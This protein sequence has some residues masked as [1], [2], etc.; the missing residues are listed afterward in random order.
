MKG[1]RT[2]IIS[3]LIA[4]LGAIQG[5]DFITIVDNPQTAGWIAT[6]IGVVMFGLRAITDSAMFSDP[7]TDA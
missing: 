2:A 5:F 6:G 4:I 3:L 7:G 1:K